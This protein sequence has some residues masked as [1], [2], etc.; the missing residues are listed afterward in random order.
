MAEPARPANPISVR[1]GRRAVLDTSLLVSL[2][3]RPDRPFATR[4]A[5]DDGRLVAVACPATLEELRD[6][7]SREGIRRAYAPHLDP[8]KDEE[9]ARDLASRAILLPDPPGVFDLRSD[10]D[11]S[12][13]FNLAIAAA[14]ELLVSFDR[15]HVLA[16][17]DPSHPQHDELRHLAPGLRIL[18]PAELAAELRDEVLRSL[19]P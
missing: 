12:V 19:G 15:R 9:F 3:G 11:D 1:R 7:L 5:V 18:H 16:V 6:V 13:F 8:P 2:A 14:A 10:P 17:G 4:A